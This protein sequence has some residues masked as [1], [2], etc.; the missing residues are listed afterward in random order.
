MLFSSLS[1][2]IVSF[3]F[4]SLQHFV[5]FLQAVAI[6]LSLLYPPSLPPLSLPLS[7]SLSLPLSPPISNTF[8]P[9]LTFWDS[10]FLLALTYFPAFLCFNFKAR[11]SHCAIFFPPLWPIFGEKVFFGSFLEFPNVAVSPMSLIRELRLSEERPA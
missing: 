11:L 10:W 2:L 9:A 3:S 8:S 6:I 4:F 1:F 5:A 7:P